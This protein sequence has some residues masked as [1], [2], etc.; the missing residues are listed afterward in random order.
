M[1]AFQ[2]KYGFETDSR[3]I[4]TGQGAES[5]RR[6][7]QAMQFQQQTG[8]LGFGKER[9][10]HRGKNTPEDLMR[11]YSQAMQGGELRPP[12]G[13][14]E[15]QAAAGRIEGRLDVYLKGDGGHGDLS[16]QWGGG[17]DHVPPGGQ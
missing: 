17:R 13:G 2:K 6:F 10:E 1:A 5:F 12:P 15:G 11:L 9:S 8:F 7:E 16:G 14:G 3:G 4:M